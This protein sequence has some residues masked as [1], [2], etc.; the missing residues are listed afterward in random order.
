MAKRKEYRQIATKAAAIFDCK[1]MAFGGF[2]MMVN[3]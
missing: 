3:E 1:R 2:K